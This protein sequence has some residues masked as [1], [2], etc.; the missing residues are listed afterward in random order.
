MVLYYQYIIFKKIKIEKMKSCNVVLV[1]VVVI[2]SMLM[3]SCAGSRDGM[4]SFGNSIKG[5][6]CGGGHVKQY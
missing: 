4:S 3:T 6:R 5:N 1:L 2:V